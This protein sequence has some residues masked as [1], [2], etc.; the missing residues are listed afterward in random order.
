V[1]VWESPFRSP[2][3][4]AVLAGA[5]GVLIFLNSLANGFAFD[6][7]PIIRDNE[8]IRSLQDIPEALVAPY[9]PGEH[10]QSLALWRP[11]VTGLY[12]L[13][14]AFWDGIPVGFHLLNVLLHG[15]V[16]A[17][18]VLLL[19]ELMPVRYAKQEEGESYAAVLR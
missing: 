10:G 11:V 8:A 7:N 12:G 18:V 9:W 15:G 4:A 19:A 1:R 5:L 6:D 3:V 14:W 2:R 17:L 13:E 16:T